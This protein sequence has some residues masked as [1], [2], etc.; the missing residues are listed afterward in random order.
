M[1]CGQYSHAYAAESKYLTAPH[2]DAESWHQ[3][4]ANSATANPH[5][6][7]QQHPV[8][9]DYVVYAPHIAEV[10]IV[11]APR[12]AEVQIVVAYTPHHV[13]D[14]AQDAQ[15]PAATICSALLARHAHA[16]A[17]PIAVHAHHREE[18]RLH[19]DDQ[20]ERGGPRVH[21]LS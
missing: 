20:R 5:P 9:E 3:H 10:R 19:T 11:V 6:G 2:M 8:A 7:S 13:N 4:G 18:H 1:Y 17:P 14:P 12:I 15:A 21:R 16:R